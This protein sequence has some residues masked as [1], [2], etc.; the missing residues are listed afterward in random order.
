MLMLMML[1]VIVQAERRADLLAVGDDRGNFS[2]YEPWAPFYQQ[3]E[4]GW[5]WYERLPE[6]QPE[7][8]LVSE[9][10]KPVV[11]P[12]TA[13]PKPLPKLLSSE[14]FRQHLTEYRDQAIDQPTPENIAAYWYL[15]RIMLDKAEQFTTVSQHVMMTDALLDEN[16]RRPIAS[17]GARAVDEQAE[18]NTTQ[19]AKRLARQAGLWFFYSSTCSYC[20]KQASVLKGLSSAY[21]FKVL[22]IALDGLPLPTSSYTNYVIDKGQ[23]QVLG[24]ET[25]PALFLV[26]PGGDGGVIQLGQG[27]L[28]GDDII[29]RAIMLGYKQ[30][31]IAETEYYKTLK[32]KPISVDQTT[33][34]AVTDKDLANPATLIAKVRAQL[35]LQQ[36]QFQ[37]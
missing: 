20:I 8:E 16:S 19:V 4:R 27:L 17:F 29:K 1:P 26:K 30:G 31:W 32:V 9:P 23:A 11:Q 28:S 24:V 6:Q 5:F 25:T 37:P 10:N 12:N 18:V 2:S 35:R 21:G 14:W 3:K 34:Q 36:R 7:P 22:A 13:P 15:Q 33:I